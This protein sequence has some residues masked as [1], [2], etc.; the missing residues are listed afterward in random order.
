MPWISVDCDLPDHPKITA[1]PTD[2]ARYSWIVILTKAKRQP[3]AGQFVSEQHF[4]EVVGRHAK[5]L[6]DYLAARL[7]EVDEDGALCVHDW[8]RYQ[9][10]ATKERQRADNSGTPSGHAVDNKGTP[11]GL[12]KDSRAR[13]AV[14]VFVPTKEGVQGGKTNGAVPVEEEPWVMLT[15]AEKQE[16]RRREAEEVQRLVK[17]RQGLVE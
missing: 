15:E 16:R 13:S 6:A 12:E 4:R 3:R 8:Q 1:L 5:H 2:G 14:G 11:R 17:E 10:K 7:L 9:W